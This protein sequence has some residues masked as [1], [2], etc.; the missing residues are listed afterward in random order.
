M[1]FLRFSRKFQHVPH[2]LE[3]GAGPGSSR[4]PWNLIDTHGYINFRRTSERKEP[5]KSRKL[6]G[7]EGRKELEK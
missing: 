6:A 2:P 7:K 1:L 5:S 3:D 4:L